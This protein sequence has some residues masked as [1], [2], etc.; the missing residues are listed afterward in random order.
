M[1]RDFLIAFVFISSLVT[2]SQAQDTLPSVF[3]AN[4]GAKKQW[5]SYADNYKALYRVICDEAFQQLDERKHHVSELHAAADWLTHQAKVKNALCQSLDKFQK[6]PLNARTTGTLEREKFTV[7]KVLFES[8]PGFY[9]TAGLFLPK[10]RQHPAPAVIYACGHTDLGFRSSTYQHL[11]LNLVNKGFIVLAFDPLGQGERKQYPV[12]ET[13]KSRI[14]GSTV[15]HSFA[16]VQTLLAGTSLTDYFIWDGIRVIDYLATRP[17]V[18]MNRIGMTGRSGGGTQ[19]AQIAASDDRIHAAAIECYVTSFERLLQSIGPQDAEQNPYNII[20]RGFD[21]ADYLHIRAPKPTLVVTTTHDFFSIQGARE[22]YAEAQHSFSALGN[23]E[24][25]QITED[26]GIHESTRKNRETLYAFFQQHL[27]LPGDPTD[28]ETAPFAQEELNVTP[29]GQVGTS[30]NSENVFS[31]NQK[32]FPGTSVPE[33]LKETVAQTAGIS[34]G[35]NLTASVYTGKYSK[36]GV[37]V[38]KYF[39]ENDR[40]DFALPVY[41]FEPHQNHNGCLIVWFH[42]VGKEKILEEPMLHQLLR[43]GYTVVAADLPGTG[44]LRDPQFS[45]DG[46]VRGIPFNYTFGANLAGKSIPGI[47]AEAIDLLWQFI[48]SENSFLGMEMNALVQG[49]AASAFLHFAVLKNAFKKVA[50]DE[51]PGPAIELLNEEIFDAAKAFAIPPGCLLYYDL[52]VL[53]EYI[54]R[55]GTEVLKGEGTDMLQQLNAFFR[56][57]D[58]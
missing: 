14:G 33:D 16:G 26:L 48:Q 30:F 4:R 6:T 39:L 38:Q 19:T 11:I 40:K 41:M 36:N 58:R 57:T 43:D 37:V 24:N 23:P 52:P 31:L 7:E 9:V 5:L 8:H 17:E 27:N 56:S 3:H 54:A 53:S 21:H 51:F 49:N 13:G 47:Q 25:L 42:P 12:A 45:G 20:A 1:K 22:S 34:F 32:Y 55:Q 15:E 44:E 46:T 28:M 29:T 10:V 35:R 2:L 18:D 50:F